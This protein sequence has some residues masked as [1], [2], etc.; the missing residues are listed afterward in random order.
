MRPLKYEFVKEI[1]YG[2]FGLV[3]RFRDERKQDWAVKWISNDDLN[4]QQYEESVNKQLK[5]TE[6]PNIIKID[7]VLRIPEHNGD[8]YIIMEYCDAGNMD[9]NRWEF[10]A[11]EL[12]SIMKGVLEG[13]LHM[14]NNKIVHRDIKPA[15]ILLKGIK[16]ARVAKLCDFGASRTFEKDQLLWTVIG[17]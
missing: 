15:N 12:M 9:E 10:S 13:L 8:L 11:Q 6:H 4:T 14:H 16:G 17:T 3:S 5:N 1:G 7:K 2:S